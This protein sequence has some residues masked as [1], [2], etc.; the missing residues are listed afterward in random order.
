[1]S[2]YIDPHL[3]E[4]ATL[5]RV[6][7]SGGFS[8]ASRATKTP[9]PTITRH[10]QQLEARLGLRLLDRTTRR[11]ALTE[12]GRR[13]FDHARAM[14]DQAEAVQAEIAALQ[15]EP[16]GRLSVVA[17]VIL[18]QA[19]VSGI[20][21]GFA[22]RHPRVAIELEW[23]TRAV[24]PV[25]DGI[26]VVI[27]LGRPP[28][29]AAVLSRLGYAQARL[30]APRGMD[31]DHIVAPRDLETCRIA[32]LGRGVEGTV[33]TMQNGARIETVAVSPC[34][35]ANDVHPVIAVAERTGALAIL[36]AFAAPE[37][38]SV[39]LPDWHLPGLEINALT[40]P[41]RGALPKV[42]LFLEALKAGV[43]SA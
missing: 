15:A 5:V 24:H 20:V 3:S 42:R 43:G 31:A 8:A 9:Q 12:A 39:C 26:D 11:V 29:S 23:T 38:W 6:V 40:A 27:R 16:S 30:Y 22:A 33:L 28:D 14:L 34:L 7:E 32:V 35:S 2:E 41:A 37:G 25:E 36:P 10:V 19:F 1:M 13:V 17:P 18:G 21:A 4:L